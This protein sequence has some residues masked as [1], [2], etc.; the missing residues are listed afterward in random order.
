MKRFQELITLCFIVLLSAC[1]GNGKRILIMASGK[2][3]V[4]NNTVKLD[5]G[6]T[7]TEKEMN[8]TGDKITVSTPSGTTDFPV[9][10]NGLYVLNLKKDTIAGSFQHTGTENHQQVISLE[11]LK[12]RIDSLEQLMR[13]ANVNAA[14]KNYFIPPNQLVKI[15]DNIN[16]QVIGPYLKMPAA[17]ESGKDHEIYKFYTNKELEEIVERLKKIQ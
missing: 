15:T 1:A 11:N 10:E 2:V 7:H 4:S 8:V 14:N 13:G 6:T 12:T 16:A 5:P 3:Q 17:F 9:P